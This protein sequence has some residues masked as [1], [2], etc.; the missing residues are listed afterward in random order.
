MYFLKTVIVLMITIMFTISCDKVVMQN[1]EAWLEDCVNCSAD[2]QFDPG[3]IVVPDEPPHDEPVVEEKPGKPE[4]N[5][6]VGDDDTVYY[7]DDPAPQPEPQCGIPDPIIDKKIMICHF[8][9]K[10]VGRKIIVNVHAVCPHLRNHNDCIFGPPPADVKYEE[11][12]GP[13][14]VADC[15]VNDLNRLY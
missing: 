1:R 13:C 2:S 7:D 14:V 6:D 11:L 3:E 10:E 8:D 4:K 9:G 15:K 5:P 12:H